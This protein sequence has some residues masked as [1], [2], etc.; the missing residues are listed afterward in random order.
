MARGGK[1]KKYAEEFKQ[2]AIE[3]AQV[4]G[5]SVSQ[6]ARDL[7]MSE[8]TLPNWLRNQRLKNGTDTKVIANSEHEAE[9]KRLRKENAQLKQERDILKKATALSVASFRASQK[10]LTEVRLDKKAS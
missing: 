10:K 4:E 7:G 5:A 6:V 3:L 2:T 8:K 9:L 1:V